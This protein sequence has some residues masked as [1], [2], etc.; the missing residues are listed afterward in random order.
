MENKDIEIHHSKKS[1]AS[2]G[3][4]KFLA[5]F[6]NMAFGAFVYFS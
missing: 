6:L 1:M 2:Y 5:E 4:G 3:F